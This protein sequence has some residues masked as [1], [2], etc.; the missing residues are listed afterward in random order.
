MWRK[1]HESRYVR[2]VCVVGWEFLSVSGEVVDSGVVVMQ[3]THRRKGQ[4]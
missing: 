4:G 2:F 1:G 3:Y